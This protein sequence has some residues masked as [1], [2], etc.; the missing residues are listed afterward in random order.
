[1]DAAIERVKTFPPEWRRELM[2]MEPHEREVTPLL[3]G[4]LD[5]HPNAGRWLHE[6]ANGA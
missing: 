6:D 2:A 4:L 3:V 5:A 1:M